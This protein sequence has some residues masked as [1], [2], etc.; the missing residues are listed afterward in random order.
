[1]SAQSPRLRL[2]DTQQDWLCAHVQAVIEGPWPAV[3]PLLGHEPALLSL[4]LRWAPG[5]LALAPG[6]LL[7][8]LEAPRVGQILATTHGPLARSLVG[9][10]TDE[11]PGPPAPLS[12]AEAGLLAGLADAVLRERGLEAW[13]IREVA[14]APL[15]QPAPGAPSP[16]AIMEDPELDC[17]LRWGCGPA[18]GDLTLRLDRPAARNL[19]EA[20]QRWQPTHGDPG[21]ALLLAAELVLARTTIARQALAELAPGDAVVFPTAALPDDGW[22]VEVAVAGRRLPGT[23]RRTAGGRELEIRAATAAATPESEASPDDTTALLTAVLGRVALSAATVSALAPGDVIALDHPVGDSVQLLVD[24]QPRGL[25][26]LVDVD[27]ELGLRLQRLT[28]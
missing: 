5:P 26:E 20:A 6:D 3:A 11:D 17:V 4:A 15:S 24:H 7:I 10:L 9:L 1:M 25:G 14:V 19:W 12:P 28:P 27:G 23:L 22:S 21:G 18:R 13:G 8:Q 2:T 16:A